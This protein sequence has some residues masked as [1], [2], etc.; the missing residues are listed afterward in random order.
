MSISELLEKLAR[1]AGAIL[2]LGIIALGAVGYVINLQLLLELDFDPPYKAE[3][4]R[5]TGLIVPFLGAVVGFF[6][7]TDE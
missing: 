2:I 4:V 1:I 6:K 7:V 3:I 5:G